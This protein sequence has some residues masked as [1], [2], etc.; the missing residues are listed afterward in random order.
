MQLTFE[1][2]EDRTLLAATAFVNAKGIV[3][4]VGTEGTDTILAIGTALGRVEVRIDV[5]GDGVVNGGLDSFQVFNNVRGMVVK[6]KGGDDIFLFYD[7]HIS[8]NITIDAGKGND[9]VGVGDLVNNTDIFGNLSIKGGDGD[10]IVLLECDVRGNV[11]VN[12]GN[13]NDNLRVGVDTFV[14]ID[15]TAKVN[16]GGGNDRIR[17]D[18]ATVGVG[19]AKISGGSGIDAFTSWY[20]AADIDDAIRAG[21]LKLSGFEN[22]A[23]HQRP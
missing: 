11:N 9:T 7:P 17:I 2:L 4:I 10:D 1:R 6:L 23:F 22:F 12:T 8:G 20:E 13:G 14:S 19:A 18:D 16:L 3:N 15:G 5:D 21:L